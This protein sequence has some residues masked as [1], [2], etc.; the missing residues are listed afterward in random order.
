M[1]PLRSE[2]SVYSTVEGVPHG[3]FLGEGPRSQKLKDSRVEERDDKNGL[4]RNASYFRL[5]YHARPLDQLDV[6]IGQ[7]DARENDQKGG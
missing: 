7:H 6:D 1:E 5:G 2:I 4:H 3:D